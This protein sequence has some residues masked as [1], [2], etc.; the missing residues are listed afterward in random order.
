VDCVMIS[1][2]ET[3]KLIPGA[4]KIVL[5]GSPVRE[6]I[7]QCRS[8]TYEP[9]FDNDLPVV[10]SFWG[11]VGAYYMNKKMEG[12]IKLAAEKRE[13]NHIHAAGANNYQ[14]MPSDLHEMGCDFENADNI[15]L[16]EYIYDMDRV[17][18]CADLV[19]CRAGGTLAELCAAGCPAIIVPSPFVAENHQEKNARIMERAG[20]AVV[21]TEAEATPEKLY[22]TAME[23]L[24]DPARLQS[25]RENALKK[26]QP[27]ALEHIYQAVKSLL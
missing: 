19:I 27:Q 15:K 14:W 16:Q 20:A 11:S 3:E 6:Q 23:L 18:A 24:R 9:L 13:F 17:M 10:A 7:L 26:A 8:K 4:K 2:S 25:M 1:F 12:F 21:V 5:T 22:D